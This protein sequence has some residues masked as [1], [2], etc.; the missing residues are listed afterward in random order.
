M[1]TSSRLMFQ[2]VCDK[3][4]VDLNSVCVTWRFRPV[5]PAPLTSQLNEFACD[6]SMTFTAASK[7]LRSAGQP[8]S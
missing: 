5:S 6:R 2:F 8:N 4:V 1:K 3:A 7:C